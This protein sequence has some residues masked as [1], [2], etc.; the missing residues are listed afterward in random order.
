MRDA[1]F[2]EGEKKKNK[3]AKYEMKQDVKGLE[4]QAKAFAE[5]LL[6]PYAKTLKH[7]DKVSLKSLKKYGVKWKIGGICYDEAAEVVIDYESLN[8]KVWLVPPKVKEPLVVL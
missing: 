3:Q 1:T 7:G 5:R 4:D 8:L 6:K 2:I